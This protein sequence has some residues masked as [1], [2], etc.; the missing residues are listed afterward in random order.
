MTAPSIPPPFLRRLLALDTPVARRIFELA[1][2]VLVL[3]ACAWCMDNKELS[4]SV[5]FL[6]GFI[7]MPGVLIAGILLFSVAATVVKDI[8][9]N[10]K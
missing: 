6:A 3:A 2:F 1:L 4:E 10:Q 8:K 7:F 5:R 9:E